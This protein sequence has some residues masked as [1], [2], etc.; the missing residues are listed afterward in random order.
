MTP[1]QKGQFVPIDGVQGLPGAR[2]AH[3]LIIVNMQLIFI[4]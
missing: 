2:A 4:E 3:M 1:T